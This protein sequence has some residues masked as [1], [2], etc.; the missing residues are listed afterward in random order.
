MQLRQEM[1]NEIG[2]EL[3]RPSSLI[4]IRNC[5]SIVEMTANPTILRPDPD[6][7]MTMAFVR[8][9]RPRPRARPRPF[10]FTFSF[11]SLTRLLT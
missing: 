4:F 6:P 7:T 5:E 11:L 3:K 2:P 10:S 8:F 9:P 1:E